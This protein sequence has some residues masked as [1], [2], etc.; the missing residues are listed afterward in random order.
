M[1]SSAGRCCRNVFSPHTNTR[2]LPVTV[3]IRILP[4]SEVEQNPACPDYFDPGHDG[5]AAYLVGEVAPIDGHVAF[6]GGSGCPEQRWPSAKRPGRSAS[7]SQ[8]R[9]WRHPT[10]SAQFEPARARE[11][12]QTAN[13]LSTLK[14][15]AIIPK[16][17]A[18]HVQPTIFTNNSD[19]LAI[20]ISC[21]RSDPAPPE[22]Q[23]IY[24]AAV[25]RRDHGSAGFDDGAAG[26][27]GNEPAFD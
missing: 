13:R 7:L 6:S 23:A 19:D 5:K 16:A 11:Q 17:P 3:S 27:L 4:R 20:G 18:A 22:W 14:A 25:E 8:A 26:L 21:G 12:P 1:F 9:S 10:S 24:G 15:I 2:A